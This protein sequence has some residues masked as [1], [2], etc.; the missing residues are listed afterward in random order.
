MRN[1]KK[2][3][4]GKFFRLVLTQEGRIFINGEARRYMCGSGY[5]RSRSVP[6]FDEFPGDNYF[7]IEAGDK[8]ID[9]C[10]GKH[11]CA[12]A[13]QNGKIYAA[14]YVY[15][16]NFEGC[17]NNPENNE[18]YPFELRLPEGYKAKMIWGSEKCNNMWV[19]ATDADGEM[20][21]LAAGQTNSLFGHD[22]ENR[23]GNFVPIKLP[24]NHYCIKIANQG[25][26][27]HG[28]D[29][30]GNL[31][32]W[33]NDIY[34]QNQEDFGSIYEGEYGR[35]NKPKKVKW[36]NEQNLK[37][38]D[39]NSGRRSCVVKCEDKDGKIVF[40]GL[41]QSEDDIKSIGGAGRTTRMLKHYINKIEIDGDR[42]VSYAMSW[43][44]VFFLLRPVE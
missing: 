3:T 33:G 34:A 44:A 21:T 16:R 7:R 13:T 37:V 6:K 35:D 1:F 31:W 28:V 8:L 4:H 19:T 11:Y 17:R 29:N 14:G 25:Y 30:N 22:S 5:D 39:V 38:L 43:S 41:C 40:Y 42:V 27:V 9:C 2:V 15:Y 18:D 12:V 32:V 36:F 26:L 20:K 10:G 23:S 24:D